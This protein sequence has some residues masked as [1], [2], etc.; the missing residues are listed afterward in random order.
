MSQLISHTMHHYRLI[1]EAVRFELVP[2]MYT[3]YPTLLRHQLQDP[4][5]QLVRVSN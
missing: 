3:T 5:A 4:L 1:S 2:S